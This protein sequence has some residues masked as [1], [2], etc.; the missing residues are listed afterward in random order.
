MYR[1]RLVSL[2]VAHAQQLSSL[3]DASDVHQA[4]SSDDPV[5]WCDAVATF[6]YQRH[7]YFFIVFF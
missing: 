1:T 3:C 7:M 4:R 5:R 2:A 6:N